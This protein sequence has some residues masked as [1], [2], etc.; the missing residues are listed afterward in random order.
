MKKQLSDEWRELQSLKREQSKSASKMADAPAPAAPAAAAAAPK[1]RKR[2]TDASAAPRRGTAE[3]R[4]LLRSY[5]R[6]LS[7]DGNHDDM[8]HIMCN[9][10]VNGDFFPQRTWINVNFGDA[11]RKQVAQLRAF[12][13]IVGRMTHSTD[14]LWREFYHAF[15]QRALMD[16]LACSACR[17]TFDRNPDPTEYDDFEALMASSAPRFVLD[18]SKTGEPEEDE[19]EDV[20]EE[21]EADESGE[22]GDENGETGEDAAMDGDGN[23]DGDA[24]AAA[25]E[26]N[27]NGNVCSCGHHHPSGEDDEEEEDDYLDDDDDEEEE[28]QEEEEETDEKNKLQMLRD[29]LMM[30]PDV[31]LGERH[32]SILARLTANRATSSSATVA[33]P[34]APRIEIGLVLSAHSVSTAEYREL[35]ALLDEFAERQQALGDGAVRFDISALWVLPDKPLSP[36]DFEI[37]TSLITSETATIRHFMFGYAAVSLLAVERAQAFQQFL[38]TTVCAFGET[39]ARLETLRVHDA[40]LEHHQV[41]AICS[42]LRYPNSLKEV[43]IEWEDE[44][45]AQNEYSPELV[46]AWLAY[47]IFHA[48]SA[49]RLDHLDLSAL[50][51]NRDDMYAF[52]AILRSP[53]PARQLWIAE[54]GDVPRGNGVAEITLPAGQRVLVQLKAKTKVRA[55]P[56][57]RAEVLLAEA[58][59]EIELEVALAVTKW[60]CVVVPGTGLGWVPITSVVSKREVVSKCPV[61][62]DGAPDEADASAWAVAGAHVKTFSRHMLDEDPPEEGEEEE[63]EPPRVVDEIEDVKLLLRMIGPGLEGFVY[64]LHDI[65]MSEDDLREML[66]S[67]PNLKQLNLKGNALVS[68]A[69]LVEQ[70]RAQQCR[71]RSLNIDSVTEQGVIL[72][73]LTALLESPFAK[74]LRYLEANGL[75]DTPEPL[76]AL[77]DALLTNDSLELLSLYLEYPQHGDVL[78]EIQADVE[79]NV[80]GTRLDARTKLAFLSAVHHHATVPSASGSFSELGHLDASVISEIFAFAAI[81]IPRSL[82]W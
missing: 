73:Q 72:E 68:I 66:A 29:F 55:F 67:C 57:A 45:S 39:E 50:P 82:V 8:L 65:D 49:A 70:Y 76:N 34:S 63:E 61:L 7:H 9:E 54:H 78:S 11:R 46:W 48:D 35:A 40:P 36:V 37:L 41:A 81:P 59:D 4:A 23:G 64:P 51:L 20:E 10:G 15:W 28:E 24:A 38:R 13:E 58:P 25:G 52:D 47:G 53:H 32:S 22:D 5:L 80:I 3:A 62:P 43:T 26:Q 16:P 18:F 42:A 6:T 1:P 19:F 33:R 60:V 31:A 21:S 17:Q 44:L 74:P 69:P 77:A 56:K 2:A 71:I 30:D 27:R 12:I 75:S 79:G 14:F